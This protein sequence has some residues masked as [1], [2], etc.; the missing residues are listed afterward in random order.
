MT[1]N[2][3]MNKQPSRFS[4]LIAA[5]HHAALTALAR[6]YGQAGRSDRLVQGLDE[7]DLK[8]AFN[9]VDLCLKIRAAGYDIVWTPFAELARPHARA[10]DDE[11]ALDGLI[12]CSDG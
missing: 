4:R 8:V 11:L 9:D 3:I 1:E 12:A 2:P 5:M 7:A 10:V 6:L